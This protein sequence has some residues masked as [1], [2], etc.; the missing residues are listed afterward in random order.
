MSENRNTGSSTDDFLARLHGVSMAAP[1]RTPV[2]DLSLQ[3]LRRATDENSFSRDFLKYRSKI[4]RELGR[5]FE[6]PSGT[7]SASGTTSASGTV[8][9]AVSASGTASAFRTVSASPV[10][11]SSAGA[12]VFSS[13]SSAVLESS[14]AAEGRRIAGKYSENT[15]PARNP[16]PNLNPASSRNSVPY[17]EIHS[18]NRIPRPSANPYDSVRPYSISGG[19][20]TNYEPNPNLTPAYGQ[21]P[22]L[23]P[24]LTPALNPVFSQ[25]SNTT[26]NTQVPAQTS[27][28]N[29]GNPFAQLLAP[30][31]ASRQNGGNALTSASSEPENSGLAPWLT[32]ARCFGILGI[33]TGLG[34]SLFS[35][36][37]TSGTHNLTALG[38]SLL[39]SGIM[40]FALT[41]LLQFKTLS[42]CGR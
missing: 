23:T 31:S 40:M 20:S 26:Q 42:P 8:S 25:N 22:A 39:V 11:G 38:L 5:G 16:E 32:S 4:Q 21:N 36:Y 41:G 12:A 24:A 18:E 30:A 7:A 3:T 13:A 15:N 28:V 35:V 27:A 6:T 9:G 2:S 1:G 34:T 29:G 37:S 33:T 17:D 10:P 14:A 19:N